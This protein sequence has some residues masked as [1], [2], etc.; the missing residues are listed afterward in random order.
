MSRVQEDVS[1]PQQTRLTSQ[2][3]VSSLCD[4]L[5]LDDTIEGYSKGLA[6]YPCTYC[7]LSFASPA[8]R[9]AHEDSFHPQ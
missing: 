8:A 3:A 9:I 6:P 7:E 2:C 5:R 1:Q 4:R